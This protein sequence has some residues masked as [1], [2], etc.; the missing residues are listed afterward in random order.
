V[1]GAS[2]ALPLVGSVF[3]LFLAVQDWKRS[4]E[5]RSNPPARRAFLLALCFDSADVLAHLVVAGGIVWPHTSQAFAMEASLAC[6]VVS[7]A[8]AVV[9]EVLARRKIERHK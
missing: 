1:R 6:A 5:M 4:Q 8:S 9:G 7:T 2:I 3:A